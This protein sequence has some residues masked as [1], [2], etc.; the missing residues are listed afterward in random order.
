M[1]FDYEF[2]IHKCF[3]KVFIASIIYLCLFQFD[4]AVF[5]NIQKNGLTRAYNNNKAWKLC[6]NMLMFLVFIC[7]S[8]VINNYKMIKGGM[9]SSSDCSMVKMLVDFLM[10]SF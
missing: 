3:S 7:E 1:I 6:V 2:A 9:I 10:I 5:S 4:Q 8:M